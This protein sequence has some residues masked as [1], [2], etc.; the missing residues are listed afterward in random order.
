MTNR[1]QS[2][3]YYSLEYYVWDGVILKDEVIAGMFYE[4]L[5]IISV[6]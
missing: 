2:S 4:S 6:Y 1:M 5:V 3:I